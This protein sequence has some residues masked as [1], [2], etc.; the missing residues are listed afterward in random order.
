MYIVEKVHFLM[1]DLF[2][3]IVHSKYDH[4]DHASS[5]V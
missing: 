3:T 4:A 5:S 1:G 2:P